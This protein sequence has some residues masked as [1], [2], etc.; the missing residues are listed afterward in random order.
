MG[1]KYVSGTKFPLLHANQ[2]HWRK[3]AWKL[4]FADSEQK[5]LSIRPGWYYQGP[6]FHQHLLAEKL[7]TEENEVRSFKFSVI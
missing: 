4:G 1:R 6:L 2:T 5:C 3:S 7:N